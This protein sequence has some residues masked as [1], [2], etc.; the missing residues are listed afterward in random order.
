MS[1]HISNWINAYLDGEL[2]GK[3]LY[4]VETHLDECPECQAELASLQALSGMMKETLL[5]EFPSAERFAANVTLRLPRKQTYSLSRTALEVTWWLT[6][7][8]LAIAWIFL[9]TTLVLSNW[10]GAA[11][12]V[13]LLNSPDSAWLVSSAPQT[14]W[15]T[16]L[17]S[18]IGLLNSNSLQALDIFE[19]FAGSIIVQIGI[20]ILYVGWTATWWARPRRRGYGQPLANGNGSLVK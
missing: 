7:V 11:G 19:G 16:S 15:L 20:A 4:L 3:R 18:N 12:G 1:D 9:H 8:T 14:T 10:V 17:L 13:G 2:R 5:P 6:P